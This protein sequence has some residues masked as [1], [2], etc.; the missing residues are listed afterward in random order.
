MRAEGRIATANGGAS[1]AFSN[2]VW[3]GANLE[4]S[5][6]FWERAWQENSHSIL[7]NLFRKSPPNQTASEWRTLPAHALPAAHTIDR[8]TGLA[9]TRAAPAPRRRSR[10][11]FLLRNA[12]PALPGRSNVNSRPAPIRGGEL[13]PVLAVLTI[14]KEAA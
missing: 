14:A 1:K 12:L 7:G 9:K 3:P 4:P 6:K 10:A 5:R 8:A 2:P 11:P 13:L